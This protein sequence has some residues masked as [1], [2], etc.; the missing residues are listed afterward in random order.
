M[1]RII[2]NNS[3]QAFRIV[4]DAGEHSHAVGVDHCYQGF[5]GRCPD[6][7]H[8][9]IEH[10]CDGVRIEIVQGLVHGVCRTQL[11]FL[12]HKLGIVAGKLRLNGFCAEADDDLQVLTMHGPGGVQDVLQEGLAGQ[13]VQHLRPGGLHARAFTGS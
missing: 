13:R 10:Q 12:Q 11:L 2:A 1:T 5:Q 4:D 8:I 3:A 6:Q 9:A 7:R